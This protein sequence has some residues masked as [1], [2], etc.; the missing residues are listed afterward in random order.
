MAFAML[1]LEYGVDT[2]LRN[3]DRKVLFALFSFAAE[4][5]GGKVWPSR[6][7]IASRSGLSS[8]SKI[9]ESLKRLAEYGWVEI[10]HRPR[11]SSVYDL[12]VPT[13][14]GMSE[15]DADDAPTVA[16]EAPEAEEA[17]NGAAS[18]S[19][20]TV[21]NG[22]VPTVGNTEQTTELTIKNP[23][24]PP[25]G[26]AGRHAQKNQENCL[27]T[28]AVSETPKGETTTTT[29]GTR[30]EQATALLRHLVEITGTPF[31]TQ[32]GSATHRMVARRLRRHPYAD[33]LAVIDAK[34]REWK[35]TQYARFL[36]PR[37]LFSPTNL[38]DYVAEQR[39]PR[40]ASMDP[41]A[42][43]AA[44]HRLFKREEAQGTSNPKTAQRAIQGL[45]A[46]L[47]GR[48]AA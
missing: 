40:N 46:A 27:G 12:R 30:A 48:L 47:S 2:R 15:D 44:S 31:D 29:P 45:K 14:P 1:P 6:Q 38:E 22:S 41:G 19:V 11:Q 24:K 17:S 25:R 21:G 23:P 7:K 42:A 10:T 4:P 18:V 8:L 32:P 37:T 33:M 35:G 3:I 39:R 5:A 28:A 26:E 34:A 20:P 16:D 9:T 13:I 36:R 43:R